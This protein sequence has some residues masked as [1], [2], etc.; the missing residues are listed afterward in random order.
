MKR[1]PRPNHGARPA[2]RLGVLET[3]LR[4]LPGQRLLDLAPLL[5]AY[6]AATGSTPPGFDPARAEAFL[7]GHRRPSA[8]FSLYR[9]QGWVA[10]QPRGHLAWEH[11]KLVPAYLHFDPASVT[12][13]PPSTWLVHFSPDVD[14]ILRHGFRYGQPDMRHLGW[15]KFREDRHGQ[16]GWNFAI[17]PGEHDVQ[18]LGLNCEENFGCSA[19]VFQAPGVR[20][21]HHA[22]DT[23]EVIFWGPSVHEGVPMWFDERRGWYVKDRATGRVVY[24]S[25]EPW[26]VASEV[27]GVLEGGSGSWRLE[28]WKV[29]LGERRGRV[30]RRVG[31]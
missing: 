25:R 3:Y 9:F 21:W 15:T 27:I 26:D 30:L 28:G 17:E 10:D 14:G 18:G 6:F 23:V 2:G 24:T 4:T 29:P 20:A 22:D 12:R 31:P 16:T 13:L 1:R 11:P 7:R 19:L 5:P 8:T